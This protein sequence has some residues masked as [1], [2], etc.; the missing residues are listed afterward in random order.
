M[1]IYNHSKT[2]NYLCGSLVAEN[3]TKYGKTETAKSAENYFCII[4]AM[5]S[6]PTAAIEVL[7]SL[8]LLHLH[9]KKIALNSA[10]PMCKSYVYKPGDLKGHLKVLK[11]LLTERLTSY[12]SDSSILSNPLTCTSHQGRNRAREALLSKRARFNDTR[13]AQN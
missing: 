13:M 8:T 12:P 11:L 6:C 1:D 2:K 5:S 3:R 4:G 7:I 10:I 9:L